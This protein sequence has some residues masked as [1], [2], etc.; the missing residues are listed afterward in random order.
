M[1]TRRRTVLTLGL[2]AAVAAVASFGPLERVLGATVRI[3]YL[4]GAW[5][6]AALLSLSAAAIFGAAHLLR[7]RPWTAT[8]SVGLGRA[9]TLLWA[10]SLLL[11]LWAMQTSWNGLYLAEPRWR[12]GVQFAVVALLLQGGI[13]LIHRPL[14]ASALNFGFALALGIALAGTEEIMHPPS[15]IAASSSVAIRL[16][17]SALLVLT[18]LAAWQLAGLLRPRSW[19]R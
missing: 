12:L 2:F 1:S 14:A 19:A 15:P 3:V 8:W 18:C 10:T 9:G 4:H 6:W 7:R 17:F 16:Y 11:S 5:V 13:L